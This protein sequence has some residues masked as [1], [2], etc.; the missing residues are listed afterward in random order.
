[1]TTL[2][3]NMTRWFALLLPE[4][5][6]WKDKH[7]GEKKEVLSMGFSRFVRTFSGIPA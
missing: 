4:L 2:A 3:W 1:M 6:R 7:A 5:G